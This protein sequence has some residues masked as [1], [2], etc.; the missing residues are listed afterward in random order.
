MGADTSKLLAMCRAATAQVRAPFACFGAAQDWK[1]A[2]RCLGA[3][4]GAYSPMLSAPCGAEVPLDLLSS[5]CGRHGRTMPAR[6]RASADGKNADSPL[7]GNGPRRENPSLCAALPRPQAGGS[8]LPRPIGYPTPGAERLSSRC[9]P[10][11]CLKSS[12]RAGKRFRP[13]AYGDSVS[14]QRSTGSRLPEAATHLV[15]PPWTRASFTD[16]GPT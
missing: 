6:R 2:P 15:L 14:A 4:S 3:V 7:Y 8:L 5:G 11:V 1:R 13:P 12:S 9:R 16:S 10:G